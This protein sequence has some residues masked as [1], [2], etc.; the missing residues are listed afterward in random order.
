MLSAFLDTLGKATRK[1]FGSKASEENMSAQTSIDQSEETPA[2]ELEFNPAFDQLEAD[3]DRDHQAL[4]TPQTRSQTIKAESR[5]VLI[6]EEI[7]L[8]KERAQSKETPDYEAS[9]NLSD[10][11]PSAL[12]LF[13]VASKE[14]PPPNIT[15][16]A[17][18]LLRSS[19]P[20]RAQDARHITPQSSL[21]LILDEPDLIDE[22]LHDL[23]S[24]QPSSS[25]LQVTRHR[26][27][28]TRITHSSRILRPD[29]PQEIEEPSPIP[30]KRR[31]QRERLEQSQDLEQDHTSE[32]RAKNRQDTRSRD[33]SKNQRRMN[34][35]LMAGEPSQQG[36]E[37]SGSFGLRKMS[38]A[39]ARLSPEQ[40]LT[41]QLKDRPEKIESSAYARYWGTFSASEVNVNFTSILDYEVR[42]SWQKPWS[43]QRSDA[44][45][46]GLL[47]THK[48]HPPNDNVLELL[49]G[50][51]GYFGDLMDRQW[52]SKL[53]PK[54]DAADFAYQD[55]AK[56]R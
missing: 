50:Q 43:Q 31:A 36:F 10:R 35:R 48:D 34:P 27:S 18:N 20:S 13:E 21:S 3:L 2:H 28:A 29:P 32:A 38:T 11:A 49:G 14:Q 19:K 24:M 41:P 51:T 53:H 26:P 23:D 5:S 15:P 47:E 6:Q 46:S 4:R 17:M 22:V 1:L 42:K 52:A 40:R 54:K 12:K 8:K 9:F 56:F 55:S 44:L 37:A 39:Q 7:D 16:T 25:S 30:R 33:L 45:G